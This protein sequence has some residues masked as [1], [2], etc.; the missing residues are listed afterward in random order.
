MLFPDYLDIQQVIK[1]FDEIVNTFPQNEVSKNAFL[2]VCQV[3]DSTKDMAVINAECES[4]GLIG[5]GNSF[6]HPLLQKFKLFRVHAAFHD[7]FGFIKEV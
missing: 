1:S 7:A 3:I 2:A 4:G 5:P 6:L